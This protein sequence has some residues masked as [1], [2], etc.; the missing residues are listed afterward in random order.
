MNFP[1]DFLVAMGMSKNLTDDTF[2]TISMEGERGLD[3]LFLYVILLYI[4]FLS[5]YCFVEVGVLSY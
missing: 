4:L 2:E 5:L 1:E 3:D